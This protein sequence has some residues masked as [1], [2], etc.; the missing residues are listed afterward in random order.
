MISNEREDVRPLLKVL[1]ALAFVGSLLPAFSTRVWSAPADVP[2]SAKDRVVFLGDSITDG[3]TYPLLIVQALAEANRPV[4]VLLNAG[5]G[6]DTAAGMLKRLDRD[7]FARHPTLVT[8][9]AGINDV[10][11]KVPDADYERD[12][13]AV[14]RRMKAEKVPLLV[15]TTTVL[16]EKH[17]EAD[18]R[19]DG[20]N[21]ILRRVAG[22][23]GFRVAEVNR[24]MREARAAGT[25]GKELLEPDQVHLTFEGYRVMTRAV[26]DGLGYGEVKVPAE[27][28]VE[29]AP[30]LVREWKVRV[31]PEG[32]PP[33]DESTVAKLEPDETWK[34]YRLPEAEP[35]SHWWKDQERRRG[36]AVNVESVVGKG[37]RYQAAATVDAGA[38]RHVRFNPG[39]DVDTIW[40][41]GKRIYQRPTEYTGW[42]AG[43]ERVGAELRAGKNA[44]VM[45]T[46]GTFFLSVTDQDV[47]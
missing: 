8:L 1:P 16:G 7:V 10:L 24:A 20:Y 3:D 12:V 2:L 19:L 21:A 43:R 11:H 32:S 35:A 40:L 17:A 29:P 46:G 31:A 25:A 33:L 34:A 5:V 18:K 45:E 23:N 26:L 14:A 6:G 37:K 22:E 47:W 9:S 15:F 27:L 42:H 13:S 30:G 4:P 38:A 39:A 28:K 36:F 44:V 41:N